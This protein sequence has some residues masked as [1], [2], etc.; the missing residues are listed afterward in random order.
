MAFSNSLAENAQKCDLKKSRK[1]RFGRFFVNTIRT[2]TCTTSP[3]S[4]PRFALC[5]R[6]LF[7][8]EEEPC[9]RKAPWDPARRGQLLGH[10]AQQLGQKKA[11]SQEVGR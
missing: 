3:L 8:E 4:S 9:P 11:L 6:C 1:N 7:F 10:W 2:S 5:I